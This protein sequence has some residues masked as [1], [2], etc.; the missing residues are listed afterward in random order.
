MDPKDPRRRERLAVELPAEVSA[1]GTGLLAPAMLGGPP[2]ASPW[3]PP[4]ISEARIESA[5]LSPISM[6]RH[7]KEILK[8]VRNLPIRGPHVPSFKISE[9][10]VS[11]LDGQ[12]LIFEFEVP[13]TGFLLPRDGT[14]VQVSFDDGIGS[15]A[16]V[17]SRESSPSGPHQAGLTV[18]LALK[19]EDHHCWHHNAARLHWTGRLQLPAQESQE[20]DVD[21]HITLGVKGGSRL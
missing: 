6:E 8:S 21:L 10:R 12:I 3:G 15:D 4:G 7:G 9:T 5:M 20:C 2:K 17:L 13:A 18:R 14:R 16:R 11:Q 19:L 1:E